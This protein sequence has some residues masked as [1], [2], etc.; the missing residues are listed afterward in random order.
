[1]KFNDK[2]KNHMRKNVVYINTEERLADVIF[3]MSQVQTDMAIVKSNK[4]ILGVITETDIYF[5]LVKEVLP[6]PYKESNISRKFEDLQ[7]IEVFRGPTAKKV[8]SSCDSL[9]WHPCIDAYEDGTIE[10]AIRIMQ[11]SDRHHLIVR[12]NKNNITGT[13]SSSDIIKSFGRSK[14]N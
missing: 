6:E 10:D 7:L 9:G 2:I 8:M 11:R 1:M 12:D 3:K 13:I 5:A 4:D 14:E